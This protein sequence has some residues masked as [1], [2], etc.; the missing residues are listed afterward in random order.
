M[1]RHVKMAEF[2]GGVPIIRLTFQ[3]V[4]FPCESVLTTKRVSPE[5]ALLGVMVL[6]P[7]VNENDETLEVMLT[8]FRFAPRV[9]A[10]NV[11]DTKVEVVYGDWALVKT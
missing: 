11:P 4:M 9:G 1:P 5:L 6:T 7:S 10:V 3:D 8:A 2:V